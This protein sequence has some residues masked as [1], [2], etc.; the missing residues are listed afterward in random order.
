MSMLTSSYLGVQRPCVTRSAALKCGVVRNTSVFR[1]LRV[2][3][4]VATTRS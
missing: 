2:S 3:T 1:M 4:D